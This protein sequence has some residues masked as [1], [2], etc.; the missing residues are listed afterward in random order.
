[1][2]KEV[3]S[4]QKWLSMAR[5]QGLAVLRCMHWI[6]EFPGW[7]QYRRMENHLVIFVEQGSVD[8]EIDREMATLDAGDILWIPPGVIR[9]TRAK[10]KNSKEKDYRLHFNI[11]GQGTEIFFAKKSIVLNCAWELLPLFEQLSSIVERTSKYDD[12]F[13]NGLCLALTSRMVAIMESNGEKKDIGWLYRKYREFVANN[14]TK[15]IIP[16]DLA[17]IAKLR[18]DY[19]SRKFKK[20]YGLSPKEFIKAEKIRIIAEFLL[21]SDCSIKEAAYYF[22]YEDSSYFCRQFREVMKCSPRRYRKM[23]I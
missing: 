5:E 21:E 11:A 2:T 17:M 15:G 4:P 9:R 20:D 14:I 23:N 16:S 10:I 22:G 6:H 18:P 7:G 19:F 3:I 8:V 1:M 13:S 12:Y